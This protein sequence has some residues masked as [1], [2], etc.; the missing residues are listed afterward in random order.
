MIQEAS[1]DHYSCIVKLLG[2]PLG[3]S[4]CHLHYL[5]SLSSASAISFLSSSRRRSHFSAVG[6]CLYWVPL[7]NWAHSSYYSSLLKKLAF[8]WILGR[9]VGFRLWSPS[10]AYDDWPYSALPLCHDGRLGRTKLPL[11]LC[12]RGKGLGERV[13]F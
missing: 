2:W 1:H 10:V 12:Q 9:L 3:Y 11:I 7:G 5:E 13:L 4:S 6:L 8:F